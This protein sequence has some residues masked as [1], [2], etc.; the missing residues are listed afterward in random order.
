MAES[1][2]PKHKTTFTTNVV[3]KCLQKNEEVGK[4]KANACETV[5]K[6]IELL[7]DD[8][9][10]TCNDTIEADSSHTNNTNN[11]AKNKE[12]KKQNLLTIDILH[13]AIKNDNKLLFM[14]NIITKH[15]PEMDE[16]TINKQI[17]EK[18]KEQKENKNNRKKKRKLMEI[19][20][21]INDNNDND[22]VDIN[23]INNSPKKKRKK[24]SKKHKKSKKKTHKKKDKNSEKSE[25]SDDSKKFSFENVFGF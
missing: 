20:D 12:K 1:T 2:E 13:D 11:S 3:K 16:K 25:N 21:D 8:I 9:L 22:N 18:N 17:R 7:T 23:S 6:F 4:V 15:F 10:N 24:K 19:N 14:D 5:I